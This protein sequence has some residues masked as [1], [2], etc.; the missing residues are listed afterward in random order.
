MIRRALPADS[1]VLA[2]LH[3]KAFEAPWDA[4]AFSELIGAQGSLALCDD[5]GFILIRIIAGEAEVLTLAVAPTARRQGL[6]RKLLEA[7]L[8]LA[9]ASGAEAVF[10]EVAAD[11]AAALALY[12]ACQLESVGRRKGYY[13]RAGDAMDALVLR[14]TLSARAA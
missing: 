6:G 14:K 8:V 10:L 13:R 5:E 7:A 11:N 12:T 3:A 1:A 4:A 9:A 2:A